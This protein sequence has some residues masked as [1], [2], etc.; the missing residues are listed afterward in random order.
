MQ[1]EAKLR[2]EQEEKEADQAKEEL[3]EAVAQKA[4]EERKANE[5]RLLAANH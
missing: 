3:K 4:E 1:K 2:E 5:L